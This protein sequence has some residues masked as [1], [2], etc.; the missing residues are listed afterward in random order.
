MMVFVNEA[1]RADKLPRAWMEKFL[2]V[3][4]PFAPHLCEE[5][6]QRLGHAETMA[7]EAWPAHDEAAL[8]VQ[9]IT[10]A[11]QVA[12]KTRGTIEVPA[13]VS[14]VAAIAAA[15]ADPKIARHLEG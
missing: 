9:T 3:L 8:A 4:S 2:L 5:L 11:V 6:W 7:Y 14:E 10:I 1:T 13:D 12:G 15:K